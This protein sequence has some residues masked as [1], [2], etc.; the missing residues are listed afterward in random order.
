[1]V[2]VAI[3]IKTILRILPIVTPILDELAAMNIN[4]IQRVD[5]TKVITQA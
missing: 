2:Q 4:I 1:M 3:I 5:Q